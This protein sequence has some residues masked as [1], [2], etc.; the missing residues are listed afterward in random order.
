MA[1]GILSSGSIN[2]KSFAKRICNIL[3]RSPSYTGIREQPCSRISETVSKFKQ[4][5]NGNI[6]QSWMPKINNHLNDIRIFNVSTF[7]NCI[8]C[9]ICN[10]SRI[11]TPVMICFTVFSLYTS[12]PVT[13]S[14]SSFS[15]SLFS[16]VTLRSSISQ[17]QEIQIISNLGLYLISK[18]FIFD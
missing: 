18:N 9:Q 5:F 11:Y 12:A 4:D 13:I 10:F 14:T 1:N 3:F 6:Q 17:N 16:F 7:Y 8:L 15:K 2:I